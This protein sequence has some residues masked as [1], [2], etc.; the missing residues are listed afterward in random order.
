M[1]I[2]KVN[3]DK[4]FAKEN[5]WCSSCMP[6]LYFLDDTSAKI[7]TMKFLYYRHHID[8]E[9]VAQ[10]ISVYL[11]VPMDEVTK[12]IESNKDTKAEIDRYYKD[13]IIDTLISM[14]RTLAEANDLT[15]TNPLKTALVG[16]DREF[17]RITALSTKF[18][19]ELLNNIILFSSKVFDEAEFT[20][21]VSQVGISMMKGV[22]DK[23]AKAKK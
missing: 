5:D 14:K 18:K 17:E 22:R 13:D 6:L 10:K 9:Q 15:N 19:S 2:L 8:E 1:V 21:N 11:D 4:P 23:I 16:E 20:E 12:C 7:C 3:K